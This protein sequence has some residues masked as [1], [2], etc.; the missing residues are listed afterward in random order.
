MV[1]MIHQLLHEISASRAVCLSV[2]LFVCLFVRT[3]MR[4]RG[5]GQRIFGLLIQNEIRSLG[6]RVRSETLIFCER[7][8]KSKVSIQF[9]IVKFIQELL[10]M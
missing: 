1:P 8:W 4:K 3:E 2:C 6:S 7:Q 9:E 5:T 10:Y